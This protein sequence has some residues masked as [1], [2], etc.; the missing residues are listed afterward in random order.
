[1]QVATIAYRWRTSFISHGIIGSVAQQQNML[2]YPKT[3]DAPLLWA[4]LHNSTKNGVQ[5]HYKRGL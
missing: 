5:I 2:F 3:V 4:N 1:M